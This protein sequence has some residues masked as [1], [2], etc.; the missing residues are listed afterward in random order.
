MGNLLFHFVTAFTTGLSVIYLYLDNLP[1]ATYFLILT[2]IIVLH[3]A[4]AGRKT[5]PSVFSSCTFINHQDPLPGLREPDSPERHD[6]N[7]D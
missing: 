6:G 2:G 1:H 3:N 5:D 7:K 4:A